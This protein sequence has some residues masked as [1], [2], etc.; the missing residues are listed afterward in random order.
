MIFHRH[1][2]IDIHTHILPGL[3][4]GPD[5]MAGSIA[6][7][8]CYEEV[9]T[10]KVVATPHFLPGT[11]WASDKELVLRSVQ[12]LQASLERADIDLKVVAGMEI[13]HH[14]KLEERIL[15]NL[16]LPLGESG[17]FLIEPA[18]Q[19]EQGDLLT[20]LQSL[21]IKGQKLIIAHP[22]RVE[23]FQ[24]KPEMLGNLVEQGLRIQVN[25]GSLLGYFG[26]K[27]Q[28]TAELFRKN[29][30]IHFVASDA[31]DHGKRAPLG[32]TEWER[33]LASP[34]GEQLLCSCNKNLAGI[35]QFTVT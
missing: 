2:F 6:I 18:F 20:S 21:L 9:G 7:A 24:R 12:V 5:D 4:D 32:A 31:H 16:V 13:A 8:R 30:C 34:G 3:D 14:K 27:S 22:E 29:H 28:D 11:A 25:T 19:G 33:L 23:A 15:A 17:Y 26:K 10:K 35:F 1:E